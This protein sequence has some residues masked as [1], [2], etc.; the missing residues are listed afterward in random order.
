MTHTAENDAGC[1]CLPCP[2]RGNDGHGLTHCAECC[3]GTGVEADTECPIHGLPSCEGWTCQSCG[4]DN[5]I[6]NGFARVTS[7]GTP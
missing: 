7:P 2:G 5:F 4:A 3:F 6:P 1:H